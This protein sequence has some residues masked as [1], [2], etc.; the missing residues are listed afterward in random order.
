[1]ALW[2]FYDIYVRSILWLTTGTTS[3][4][5]QWVGAPSAQRN[6][7]S[8]RT[9]YQ[10]HAASL[11]F[12][13]AEGDGSL[14]SVAVFFNKS[15]NAVP[16]INAPYRNLSTPIQRLRSAII[17]APVG[18]TGGRVVDLAPWPER[19]DASGAVV[20]RD[21][22][23]AEYVRM[24]GERVVP[25]VLVFC[26]GYRQ[27]FSFFDA[28]G[29]TRRPYP[30][31]GDADVR[32]VWR[33]DEPAVGFIGFVRP[34]LGAIP[35]LS[36]MQAQLWLLNLLA[37]ARLADGGA[38]RAADESHY[39]LHMPRG[40]RIR[41]GVD[42]ESYVY[43]LALD[44]GSAPGFLEVVASAWRRRHAGGWRLPLAWAL[45]ANLNVKFRLKGP[46]RWEGAE[47]VM[48]T[49]VWT[50]ICRRRWFYGGLPLSDASVYP[51]C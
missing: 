47:E 29:D 28:A 6:H 43:Q 41:Y 8:R 40:G 50:T 30:T 38:L 39:R 22:G 13:V 48:L 51:L 20:F 12:G 45:G 14:T 31:A 21:N 44:M 9:W 32:A 25:D 18:E 4:L 24:R 16:Y 17:Q 2:T 34:G 26:T 7:V 23:R 46:W 35:P 15:S 49:E 3:G 33:R 1:M 27:E 19:I 36:E 42:H 11:V 10:L 5:D 37:P